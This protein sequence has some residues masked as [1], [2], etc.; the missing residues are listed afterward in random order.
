MKKIFL[1]STLIFLSLV[2]CK[3]KS[4]IVNMVNSYGIKIAE[5]NCTNRKIRSLDYSSGLKKE[6]WYETD[7]FI[8]LSSDKGEIKKVDAPNVIYYLESLCSN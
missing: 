7:E 6:I 5:Y 2:A 4:E 1:L 8:N 3:K